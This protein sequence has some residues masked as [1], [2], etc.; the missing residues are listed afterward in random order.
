MNPKDK[1]L[2]RIQ[3]LHCFTDGTDTYVA[4]DIPDAIEVWKEMTGEKYRSDDYDD[5]EPIQDKTIIKIGCETDDFDDMKKDR[6]LFSELGQGKT[7]PFISAPAWAWALN[8]GRGFL[9]STEW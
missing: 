4:F 1:Q 8:N 6:P 2:L 7:Y 5:F 3:R 9:C